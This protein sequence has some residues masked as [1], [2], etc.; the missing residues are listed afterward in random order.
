MHFYTVKEA[1]RTGHRLRLRTEEGDY[2][3]EPHVL[4]RNGRGR[5]LLRAF[6]LSGPERSSRTPWK[7]FDLDRIE[8]A[9]EVEQR[10]DT[11]RPGY[12]PAD[13][14]MKAGIIIE[15]I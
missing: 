8:Q 6:Q 1:I 3:V 7:L 11:P 12:R 2:T 13:P 5:T 10:F 14:A 4:G 15:Q 9:V